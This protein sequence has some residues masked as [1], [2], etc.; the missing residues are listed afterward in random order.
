M[1]SRAHIIVLINR[2]ARIFFVLLFL[3]FQ[4]LISGQFKSIGVPEI[5]NITQY[6][7]GGKAQIWDIIQDK[8]GNIYLGNNA[9]VLSFDGEDWEVLPVSN[10]SIVRSLAIGLDG[11]IYVGAYNEIGV[12]EK[13][14]SERLVYKSLNHLIPE[15]AGDY[16]D[17]WKI[18]QTR[19][20]II[21]QSFE[22]IYMYEDDS[23]EV[24]KPGER[25]GYSYYLNNNFYV[26][27]K[28]IGLRM[29][30]NGA[31]VTISDDPMFSMDEIHS[32]TPFKSN[33]LLI[34]TLSHGLHILHE[35]RLQK[36]ETEI[37]KELEE[38]QLYSGA[39]HKETYLFGTIKNGLYIIDENGTIIQHLN[40]SSGLKNNTILSLFLDERRNLWLGLDN[41]IDYLKTSLP[42]SYLNYT[43]NIETA[44]TSIFYDDRFY[45]GTNQGL[46][47]KKASEL[48][49]FS[50]TE[51][52]FVRG[53]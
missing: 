38:H 21:F 51:F 11:R 18:Y 10:N 39:A 12:I 32:I 29:L 30:V 17:V 34:G 37:S 35:D 28:G 1:V 25:F 42:I 13:S 33:D 7:Y 47:T 27:E 46:F 45:V 48:E 2:I 36:W 26:V 16:D 49:N 6:E 40:R 50:E 4:V 43:F 52:E 8:Q 31:L 20:G 53:N 41:G 3:F 22:Y 24:I 19:F 14:R 9:G 5:I 23:I 44:Y 15:A